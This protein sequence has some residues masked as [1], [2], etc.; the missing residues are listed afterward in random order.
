MI[1][2]IHLQFFLATFA[3]WVGGQQEAAI[4]YLIDENRVPRDQLESGA[5]G[6][7][8]KAA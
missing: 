5:P 8:A 3:G 4:T 1:E 2:T 6:A 7:P